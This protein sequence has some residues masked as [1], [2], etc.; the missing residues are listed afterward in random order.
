MFQPFR[1]KKWNAGTLG[2]LPVLSTLVVKN[3]LQMP[4]FLYFNRYKLK[5]ILMCQ[6]CKDNQAKM[7][8]PVSKP[9]VIA[10]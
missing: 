5:T 4:R 6:P 3:T 1:Q 2:P 9:S 10:F 8:I 7:L